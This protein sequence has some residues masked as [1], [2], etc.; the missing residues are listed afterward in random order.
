MLESELRAIISAVAGRRA[1]DLSW[2]DLKHGA[3]ELCGH[4]ERVQMVPTASADTTPQNDRPQA[5]IAEAGAEFWKE[6]E[7]EFY[8]DDT[9]ENTML[10][11]THI[12]ISGWR[13]AGASGAYDS[14]REA[15]KTFVQLARDAAKGLTTLGNSEL[16]V[17]WLDAL[18]HAKDQITGGLLYS[19]VSTASASGT[20]D[21][22]VEHLAQVGKAI[23]R[24]GVIEFFLISASDPSENAVATR[25]IGIR[26]HWD[27]TTI[28]LDR[29]FRVSAAYCRELRSLAP[30][31]DETIET[32]AR[33]TPPLGTGQ[34]N[35]P[36][37]TWKDLQS[38]FS[39]GAGEYTH[40]S[41]VWR[42]AFE[43]W[44]LW[45]TAKLSDETDEW[46]EAQSLFQLVASKAVEKLSLSNPR[47]MLRRGNCGSTI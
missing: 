30:R 34:S 21:P 45:P 25:A 2:E 3:S 31:F 20:S 17:G 15:R 33:T 22:V 46:R 36:Q 27:E 23:P 26:P 19:K 6:R 42:A 35:S 39:Q 4:Y 47:A 10:L 18:S 7:A 8:K 29:L 1:N 40:L 32:R 16:S 12:P 28:T 38:A 44:R 13:F 5:A 11:A 41:A 43:Q 24:G 14:T 9:P 37:L